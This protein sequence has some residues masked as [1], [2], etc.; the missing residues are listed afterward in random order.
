MRLI[1]Y[2]PGVALAFYYFE[3]THNVPDMYRFTTKQIQLGWVACIA[4]LLVCSYGTYGSNATSG[5]RAGFCAWRGFRNMVYII[6][7]D[8]GWSTGVVWVMGAG[9]M[10]HGGAITSALASS[11]FGAPSRLVYSTFLVHLMLMYTLYYGDNRRPDWF[12]VDLYR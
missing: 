2:L 3:H 12:V 4:L 11:V 7:S 5:L 10:G 8:L 6:F 1:S 9:L